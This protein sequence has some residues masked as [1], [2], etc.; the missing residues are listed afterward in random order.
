MDRAPRPPDLGL[1]WR[2]TE[3]PSPCITTLGRAADPLSSAPSPR[4][5]VLGPRSVI[6]VPG[7]AT[8]RLSTRLGVDSR[9]DFFGGRGRIE[10]A[11]HGTR[12]LACLIV[13]P[14]RGYD[15]P[16]ILSSA[17]AHSVRQVLTAYTR[18]DSGPS[19]TLS[20][21]TKPSETSTDDCGLRRNAQP[22]FSHHSAL[23]FAPH[24][25]HSNAY[26]AP[27]DS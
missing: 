24:W 20:P 11:V 21:S 8:K 22:S 26:R 7:P 15:E 25:G 1:A 6:V 2:T 10:S 5:S 17:S 3:P 23:P 18:N 19:G 12:L 9:G 14:Q 13:A 16:A 4:C 27:P